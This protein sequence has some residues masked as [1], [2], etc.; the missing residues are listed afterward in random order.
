M[1]HVATKLALLTAGIARAGSPALA[2]QVLGSGGP[3]SSAQASSGTLV[4]VDGVARILVDAGPGTLLRA[5]ENQVDLSELDTVLV[6]PVAPAGA[7]VGPC[8][9]DADCSPASAGPS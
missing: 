7:P 4:L 3:R 8:Q 2:V 9:T 5:G 1:R 6:V